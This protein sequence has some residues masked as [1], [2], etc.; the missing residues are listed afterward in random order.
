M[1]QLPEKDYGGIGNHIRSGTVPHWMGLQIPYMGGGGI[2][3]N[4]VL[5]DQS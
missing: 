5:T 2:R 3:S 1:V 4:K